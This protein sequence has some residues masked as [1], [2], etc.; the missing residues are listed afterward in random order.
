M[1]HAIP[2]SFGLIGFGAIGRE[3]AALSL[4]LGETSQLACVLVRPGQTA[5]SS[6]TVHD[7]QALAATGARL[8][9][10]CAGHGAVREHVASLLGLGVDV[11]VT[12]VGA[13]ADPLLAAEL[14]RA[15]VAGGG[16]LLMAA[17]AIGGLDA[18][19]AARLNEL[20]RVSY[21]SIKPPLAWRD[22]PA[23]SRVDLDAD[24][25]EQLVFEGSAREAALQFPRNANVAAAVAL[26]SLGLDRTHTRL[27]ASRNVT[28]P[29]G[30]IEAEGACGR[31][32][33]ET[34]AYA[35]ASNAKTSLL[36]ANS[37]LQ[38]ARLGQGIPIGPLVAETAT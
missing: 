20:S 10:E 9:L 14:Q 16:R 15:S 11:V 21:V 23:E 37:L 38:C 27:I 22:T 3:I 1:L 30:L 29:L 33:F 4:R 17:G 35:A 32:R 25:A 26:C 24:V 5:G 7:A 12:S 28:D 36:T 31:F 13:L 18:L 2:Q 34:F 19:L 8:V 6:R